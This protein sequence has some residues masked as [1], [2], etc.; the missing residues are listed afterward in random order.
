MRH[1][2]K[3][4]RNRVLSWRFATV[5]CLAL[6]A[7]PRVAGAQMKEAAATPRDNSVIG[8]VLQDLLGYKG[9]DSTIDGAFGRSKP[10]PLAARPIHAEVSIDDVLYRL[11]EEPWQVLTPSQARASRQAARH[12]TQRNRS[13]TGRFAIADPN[14]ELRTADEPVSDVFSFDR[15][16]LALLPGYSSDGGLSI[17]RMYIPWSIH[18]VGATFVLSLENGGWSVLVRQFCYY[19]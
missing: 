8:A 17:V 16:I 4:L 1:N 2:N 11:K 3:L 18:S 10:L 19:L 6:A 15:P 7:C 12:L 5:F 9:K 13:P 14:V